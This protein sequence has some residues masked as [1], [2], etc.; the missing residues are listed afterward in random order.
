[1]DYIEQAK[2][3]IAAWESEK[4]GFLNQAADFLLWPA[5]KAA[6]ALIPDAVQEAVGNAIQACVSGLASQTTKTF[7]A[8]AIAQKISARGRELGGDSPALCHGLEAA[9]ES[10]R[11]FWTYHIGYAALEGGIAGAAGLAGLAAD[12]PALFAI[13]VRELQEIATCYGVDVTIDREH[14]YLLH[15]LRAGFAT[16][17]KAKMGFIVTLKEVEQILINVAWKKMAEDLASKQLT[18]HSLLA[19]IRQFAKTLGFQLTKRKALQLVP[20]I[21]AIVGASLNGTLAN[22]IGKAAYISYRRRWIA[23]QDGNDG[24]DGPALVAT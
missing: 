19:G 22:D 12:I 21:G 9:D 10:A 15:V 13:L 4:P 16:N 1:M 23:E 11:E 18:K 7:D 24:T 8:S 5:E 2:Q 17:V 6:E 14:D 20:V 3:E